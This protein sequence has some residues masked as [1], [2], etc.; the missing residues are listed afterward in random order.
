MLLD[1]VAD[2]LSTG[3]I[4]S[5]GSTA[6][7][8]IYKAAMPDA[9]EKAVAV[10]ETGGGPSLHAMSG[11][12]GSAVATRPRVQVVVRS[13]SYSTGRQKAQDAFRLLDGLRDR[14][15]NGVRYMGGAAVQSEP[16]PI[17]RDENARHLIACNYEFVKA[18]S[19]A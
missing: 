15:V 7:Y 8:G 3:G 19:T 11:S 9:P 14:T 1:D 18:M 6:S 12:A 17:G 5:V 16:F 2:L 4:G 13:A 10:Y